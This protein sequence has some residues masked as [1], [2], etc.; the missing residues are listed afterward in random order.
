ML[1]LI[2][3]KGPTL[4]QSPSHIQYNNSQPAGWSGIP[5][6]LADFYHAGSTVSLNKRNSPLMRGSENPTRAFPLGLFLTFHV[7]KCILLTRFQCAGRCF[8]T[9]VPPSSHGVHVSQKT[10]RVACHPLILCR[11]TVIWRCMMR[12]L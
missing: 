9:K 4:G 12:G 10:A 8:K 11:D 6:R 1:S 5:G 3:L 2:S 7:R